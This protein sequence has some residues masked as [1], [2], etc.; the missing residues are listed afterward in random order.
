MK[1]RNG[2]KKTKVKVHHQSQATNRPEPA[3]EEP[4]R[5]KRMKLS[6]LKFSEQKV[7]ELKSKES[8]S[9]VVLYGKDVEAADTI[10]LSE[11]R[12]DDRGRY[13][14]RDS[15]DRGAGRDREGG[16]GFS[17]YEP[18]RDRGKQ[19]CQIYAPG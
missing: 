15:F 4:C 5:R 17:S 1:K 11:T 2:T 7:P 14:W 8:A 18:P 16:R 19:L 10:L 13:N 12:L 6:D 9:D 3:S